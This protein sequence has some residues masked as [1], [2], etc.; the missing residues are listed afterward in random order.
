MQYLVVS[1]NFR[2][3]G[4]VDSRYV[5]IDSD[6]ELLRPVSLDTWKYQNVDRES[7]IRRPLRSRSSSLSSSDSDVEREYQRKRL[8]RER[9]RKEEELVTE[10]TTEQAWR[11]YA[12]EK[13]RKKKKLDEEPDYMKKLKRRRLEVL[14][15]KI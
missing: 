13:R 8:E 5:D 14:L 10:I 7:R 6:D 3:T 15:S 11:D 12:M 1:L 4:E 9:K 2:K